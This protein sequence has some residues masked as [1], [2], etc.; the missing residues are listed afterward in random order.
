[1]HLS[2]GGSIPLVGMMNSKFPKAQFMVTGVLGPGSN[3][4]CPNEMVDLGFLE[5]V[6]YTLV[7]VIGEGS[8]VL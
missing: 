4:H 1:M 2:M 6:M 5:K 7:Q 8:K 3:A